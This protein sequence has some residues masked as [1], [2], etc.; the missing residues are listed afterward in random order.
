MITEYDYKLIASGK[1]IETY[2]Y[3]DKLVIKGYTKRKSNKKKIDKEQEKI[4]SSSL[5]RTRVKIRRLINA[6]SQLNKFITLTHAKDVFDLKIS[7]RLFNLYTQR[8]ADRYS[9]FQYLAVPEFQPTSQRVHY[10]MLCNLRYVPNKMIADIWGNGF[11][12]INRID[13]VK[14]VGK[15][16]C[17]YLNK[18]MCDNRLF[19]KKKFF[20]SQNLKSPFELYGYNAFNYFEQNCKYVPE[21]SSVIFENKYLGK[22]IYKTYHLENEAQKPKEWK[23]KSIKDII[24]ENTWDIII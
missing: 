10:H 20:Y 13:R 12:K 14:N 4:A 15:Y 22:V 8:M 21:T 3:P 19:H 2:Q 24:K 17:K 16:V 18:D 1:E 9:E 11:I 23:Y 7:N 5:Y 6:N